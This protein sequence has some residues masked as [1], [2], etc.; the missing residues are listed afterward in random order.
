M[1]SSR[2]IK[3]TKNLDIIRE[4]KFEES[5]NPGKEED[6]KKKC[7]YGIDSDDCIYCEKYN[8]QF[9]AMPCGH[10]YCVAGYFSSTLEKK[11]LRIND[12]SCFKCK[13]HLSIFKEIDINLKELEVMKG[14]CFGC[15]Q[16]I[17]DEFQVTAN[18]NSCIHFCNNCVLEYSLDRQCLICS[19][20]YGI[21]EISRL[22]KIKIAC[23]ACKKNKQ[24]YKII[25]FKICKC[26]LRVCLKCAFNAKDTKKCF[27]G[28]ILKE[29]HIKILDSFLFK[30]CLFDDKMYARTIKLEG[31]NCDCKVCNDCQFAYSLTDCV[32]DTAFSEKIS[33][34]LFELKKQSE[35]SMEV[36]TVNCPICFKEFAASAKEQI[37]CKH[38]F[39]QDC[40]EQNTIYALEQSDPA[41]ALKCMQCSVPFH[42]YLLQTLVKKDTFISLCELLINK[43]MKII[44]CPKCQALGLTENQ[45]SIC[46]NCQYVM[47]SYCLQNWIKGHVCEDFISQCVSELE[48]AGEKFSQCPE[49][50]V[51]YKK[52]ENCDI[53]ICVHCETKFCFS[54]GCRMI[55]VLVHGNYYHKA[56]CWHYDRDISEEGK[57][58]FK[59]DEKCNMCV[60]AGELCKPPVIIKNQNIIV[61]GSI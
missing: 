18:E 44:T 25:P 6:G 61:L 7:D 33:Q 26:M 58:S 8:S 34:K 31:K 5:K 32:C 11:K 19:Y 47:C 2:I 28:K 49:C 23:E 51:P 52:D 9:V 50:R 55:P 59:Y 20:E 16:K 14:F 22:K 24:N 29:S 27:C 30:T 36:N 38:L 15:F 54:C 35:S 42:S 56:D 46:E 43:H 4:L 39:C 12:K 10:N 40:Y 41:K 48:L 21:K 1:A 60:K 57:N 17:E 53:V 37:P 45:S 13:T 3:N